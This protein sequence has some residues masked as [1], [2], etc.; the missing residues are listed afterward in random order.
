MLKYVIRRTLLIFPTVL[1]TGTIAFFVLGPAI[2]GDFVST[3]NAGGGATMEAME[4]VRDDVGLSDPLIIQYARWLGNASKGNLGYSRLRDRY[5]AP[6]VFTRLETTVTMALLSMVLSA[7]IA[8]PL[9]VIAAVKRGSFI[10]QIIRIITGINLAMPPFWIGLIVVYT[11]SVKFN[12]IPPIYYEPI[13][14]DPVRNLTIMAFPVIS[15]ALSSSAVITRYMRSMTLEVLYLDYVRT[16]RAKGLGGANLMINHVIRNAM[17]PV[18]TMFGFYFSITVSGVVVIEKVFN[19]HGVGLEL[20]RA[21]RGRD[22]DM[23]LG[24]ILA[25]SFLISIWILIIDIMYAVI[26]PR[27][28]Y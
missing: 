2:P 20:V 1:F 9:G 17:I 5:V 22:I 7:V 11:S 4:K 27:I 13:Y 18:L 8:I 14:E 28:R 6:V 26:D 15:L 21:V 16:A 3:L 23:I 24:I 12:W 10:D 19:V 25:L